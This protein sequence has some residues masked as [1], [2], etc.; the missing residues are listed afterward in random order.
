MLASEAAPVTTEP[1]TFQGNRG[2][3]YRSAH[4]RLLTTVD[5]AILAERMPGFV[6]ASLARFRETLPSLP[7]PG[8]GLEIFVLESR[9]EWQRFV[10]EAFG[11]GALERY[12]GIERGGFTERGRSVLWDIGI[13]DTF[14]IMAHEGWHQYAQ[15]TLRE[16]LPAWLD[17][18]VAVWAEGFR[19]NPRAPAQPVFL[20]WANV[21]RFDQLRRAAE[22][23]DL[24]PLGQLLTERPQELLR[25]SGEATLT[26]YAQCWALIHYMLADPVRRETLDRMLADAAAG[27]MASR[28]RER[29]G[30]RAV[31]SIALRRSGIELWQAYVGDDLA[32]EERAFAAFL[33][34]V[35]EPGSKGRIVD[36]RS[37]LE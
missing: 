31:R 25:V 13:Q 16:P 10:A 26:Y 18:G 8:A 6:E 37:P 2:T 4:Y 30:D 21:E 17:E 36:G 9:S 23:G 3:A 5:R 20:P 22:R 29:F 11:P 33:A 15:S 28:V 7:E 24:M 35:V 19:W 12:S 34:R 32:A 14:A 27:R 1:W